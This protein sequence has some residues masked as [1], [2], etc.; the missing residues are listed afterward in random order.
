METIYVVQ[1]YH[2][3]RNKSKRI[4]GN[5]GA[6]TCKR[7]ISQFPPRGVSNTCKYMLVDGAIDMSVLRQKLFED[8]ARG[9]KLFAQLPHFLHGTFLQYYTHFGSLALRKLCA[10]STFDKH[11]LT[12]FLAR[13]RSRVLDTKLVKK[14]IF[15]R[16]TFSRTYVI[17]CAKSAGK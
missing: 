3:F 4:S 9:R 14:F 5:K 17:D 8:S 2:S 16:G 13:G 12:E 11:C 1:K 10:V 15:A 6:K 7:R